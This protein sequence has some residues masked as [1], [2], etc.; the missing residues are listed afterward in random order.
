MTQQSRGWW[1]KGIST[2]SSKLHPLLKTNTVQT[3][4]KFYNILWSHTRVSAE[5]SPSE[6]PHK[7][8][9][10]LKTWYLTGFALMSDD[11]LAWNAWGSL[12]HVRQP[13]PLLLPYRLIPR[14]SD[15]LAALLTMP[16]LALGCHCGY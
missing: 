6:A 12:A 5:T 7:L 16:V 1:R 9:V 4:L 8:L 2:F 10:F 13:S 11:S 3:E 14:T 15:L